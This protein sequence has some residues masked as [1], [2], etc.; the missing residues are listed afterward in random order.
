M[1]SGRLQ[2]RLVF[3][4]FSLT[5]LTNGIFALVA[6]S[7]EKIQFSK[8]LLNDARF[9][10]AV[11]VE[12][13]HILLVDKDS[14]AFDNIFE[15]R[16][17]QL[18]ELKITL[19]DENWWRKA[20][21]ETRIPL[22]GFP[23]IQ[24]TDGSVI[25]S[26]SENFFREVF[27]PVRHEGRLVGAIGVGV[28]LTESVKSGASTSDFIVILLINLLLGV[29]AAVILSQSILKPLSGLMEGIDAFAMGNYALRVSTSGQGE[30]KELCQT[31]NRM[32]ATVQE[33]VKEGLVRNRLLDEKL[34][35]LWEIYELTR[36][37]G[38]SLDL[39]QI[40]S[41]FLDKAQTLSFSSH[42]QIIMMDHES[43]KLKPVITSEALP[44]V[45]RQDYE[46]ALNACFIE[47]KT[48]EKVSLEFSMIFF[49]L[50]SGARVQGVLFLAKR[51]QA[52]YSEN[53]KRFLQTIAPVAASM[54]DN[55]R[56]YEEISLW[57]SNL[58]GIIESVSAAIAAI[59][60]RGNLIVRN[61]RLLSHLAGNYEE[62]ELENFHD[63]LKLLPDQE[64]AKKVMS[65]VEAYI[66]PI[67][68]AECENK[69][70]RFKASFYT[71]SGELR[72][73]E[74][75]VMPLLTKES[76]KGCVV[77]FE[78]ITEQKLIEQQMVE[79]EKWA[80]LGKL[81]ASVAHEIRNP[82]V[83][84]RSL[85]E[86]IGE[87]VIGDQKEHVNV[88]LGEVHR[89]NRVVAE[90]LSL[91]RPEKAQREVVDLKEVVNELILLVRHEA[92]RGGIDKLVQLPD[93]P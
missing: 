13:A 7:R 6:V 33:N 62:T 50:L 32:A 39:S 48:Q 17:N 3:L 41:S 49:P 78:D 77:V 70:I 2:T 73:Y 83:A 24:K 11:L 80:V 38:L 68:E 61:Q 66:L 8:D 51:D 46:N 89:L 57:N 10:G 79:S 69:R 90:L 9:I 63:Y 86:L 19:Y 91:V 55:A 53:I 88:I 31:F 44:V 28:P 82:L 5:L 26:G 20:G 81:A 72:D 37:M 74:V 59:D 35:E 67:P 76:V 85:V 84:I 52:L 87:E 40:L 93:E 12:P 43:N 75:R 47:G 27:F 30:L 34:Q 1:F 14:K 56:L 92:A 64:F 42:S 71:Q 16:N 65:A 29:I 22:E 60:R 4:F 15:Q 21:D 54:I 36:S 58:Q 23:N 45:H 25:K 18:A